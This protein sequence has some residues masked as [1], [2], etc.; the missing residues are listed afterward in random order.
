MRRFLSFVLAVALVM[1]LALSV[2]ASYDQKTG[3]SFST[4]TPV[5]E[6]SRAWILERFGMYRTLPEL[7]CA[8]DRF[9]CENFT[10]E[11][12]SWGLIQEF[13]LD[14]FLFQKDFH[15]V[16]FDF[17]CFVKC[18]VTVW[19][20]HMGRTDVQA[21][22]YDVRLANNAAHSYNFIR[23]EGRTWF[24][25][26][27]TNVSRTAKGQ[28]S[29]GFALLQDMTPPSSWPS[30]GTSPTTSTEKGV[31]YADLDRFSGLFRLRPA[32]HTHPL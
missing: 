31:C 12:W 17:S 28:S 3:G 23:E 22:V 5:T 15:G 2:K 6:K 32:G 29:A 20:Q 10:Y 14:R 24:I 9:G 7:L 26:M 13:D 19:S 27:T 18:V 16:C 11:A 21:F 30:G 25:C 4:I 8:I 1:T